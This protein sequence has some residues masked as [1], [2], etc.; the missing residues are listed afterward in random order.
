[1]RWSRKIRLNRPS[2]ADIWNLGRVLVTKRTVR[3]DSCSGFEHRRRRSWSRGHSGRRTVTIGVGT[4]LPIWPEKGSDYGVASQRDI[5]QATATLW[6]LT[7]NHDVDGIRA[8]FRGG[9]PPAVIASLAQGDTPLHWAARLRWIN[10]AAGG[11]SSAKVNS[12]GVDVLLTLIQYLPA[13]AVNARNEAGLTPLMVAAEA[14]QDYSARVL[15]R[16]GASQTAA[17]KRGWTPLFF[18]AYSGA[19][20]VIVTLL[21]SVLGAEGVWQALNHRDSQGNTAFMTAIA[22]GNLEAARELLDR[23]S[24]INATNAEGRTALMLA[25]LSEMTTG[26]EI[27]WLVESGADENIKDHAGMTAM[28]YIDATIDG[29]ESA[30]RVER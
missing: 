4:V 30:S 9:P 18:A 16:A 6:S 29:F 12:H 23:G 2:R 17:D 21:G 20:S 8:F 15:L 14:G 24:D 26:A 10:E 19:V 25:E 22:N 28:Q 7:K 11:S 5:E 27:A 1:M 13:V 3:D